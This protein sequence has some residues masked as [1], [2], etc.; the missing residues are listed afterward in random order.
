MRTREDREGGNGN[1]RVF[2]PVQVDGHPER[3]AE[4]V[5]ND[6]FV[7]SRQADVVRG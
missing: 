6:T 1:P 7:T 3:K 4:V 5:A 2:L